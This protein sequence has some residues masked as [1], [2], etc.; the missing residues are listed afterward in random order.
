VQPDALGVGIFCFTAGAVG[1]VGGKGFY[2]AFGKRESLG[3]TSHVGLLSGT[4]DDEFCGV[5]RGCQALGGFV[6]EDARGPVLVRS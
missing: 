3:L 5:L 4:S 6:E 1:V 2:G